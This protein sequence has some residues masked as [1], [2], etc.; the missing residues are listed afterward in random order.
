MLVD[1][2]FLCLRQNRELIKYSRMTDVEKNRYIRE[3]YYNG[4]SRVDIESSLYISKHVVDKALK[5]LRE[6]IL[7]RAKRGPRTQKRN[8]ERNELIIKMALDGKTNKEIAEKFNI[9]QSYVTKILNKSPHV[10][11]IKEI[12]AKRDADRINVVSELIR[13]GFSDDDIFL[14]TS[15]DIAFIKWVRVMRFKY[16][17]R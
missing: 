4:M 13:A 9:L 14:K 15:I 16:V 2:I 3:L 1:Y 17:C 10:Y 7:K 11:E 8:I 12:R 5:G 6:R